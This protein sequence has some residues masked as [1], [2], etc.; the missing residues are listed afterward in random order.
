MM[1]G[2]IKSSLEVGIKVSGFEFPSP[3]SLGDWL[4]IL[5]SPTCSKLMFLYSTSVFSYMSRGFDI[6]CGTLKHRI[7]KEDKCAMVLI[8]GE[9]GSGKSLAAVAMADKID[10]SFSKHCT[11]VYT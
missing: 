3:T 11:I 7:N 1:E 6:V 4:L 9:M 2:S 10:P 8:V 5:Q